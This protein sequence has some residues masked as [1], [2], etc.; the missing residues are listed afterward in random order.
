MHYIKCED[1]DFNQTL[2]KDLVSLSDVIKTYPFRVSAHYAALIRKKDDAV[3]RQCIPDLKELE[4]DEQASD[5][6]AETALS[7]VPGLIHRYPDRVV[8]LVS[9]RCP[10]YCRFCMRKRHVGE[11]ER[12]LGP[13]A[14][15]AALAYIASKPE[16]R[17]VILSGGDP[18]MLDDFSL[19]HV[20]SSLRKIQHVS[21]IRIGTRI[22]VTLPDRVTP[23]LCAMLKKFHPLYL[24]THFN[25]PSE[26]TT[27]SAQAC[28]LLADA[29]IPLGNQSVLLRG[30]NDTVGCMRELVTGLLGLRIRPYYIHQMDLVKGTGHF[31][32]S[33]ATGLEIIRGLRGHVSG[34]AVPHYVIDLPNGKGKVP[35]LPE[36]VVRKG[37]V[38]TVMTY[39]GEK[40]TYHDIDPLL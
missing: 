34:L 8:L 36:M 18:L 2:A 16:I 23:E 5:P 22:P 28:A 39:Q 37:N 17:D 1:L 7:P 20:L 12:P 21:I 19:H 14:L 35:L 11:G 32:T 38:L 30:V 27:K 15:Q 9:N 13:A 4:D 40:V 31:R 24:N 33:V 6:L 10:V 26:I 25:H 3:W 29:G